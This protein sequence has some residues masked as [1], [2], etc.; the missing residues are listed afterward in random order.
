MGR[1]RTGA[2]SRARRRAGERTGSGCCRVAGLCKRIDM[3]SVHPNARICLR[4]QE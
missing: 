4:A 1:R 3:A 2:R